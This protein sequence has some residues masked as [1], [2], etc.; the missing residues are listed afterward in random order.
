MGE[1]ICKQSNG[2]RINL[3][4]IQAAH[5]TQYK[6]EKSPIKKWVEDLNRHFFKADKQMVNKHMKQCSTQ[7]IIREIKTKTTIRYHLSVCDVHL[8]CSTYYYFTPHLY[9]HAIAGGLF[10]HFW[11]IVSNATMYICG[12]IFSFLLGRYTQ[13]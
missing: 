1:N 6:K 7:F 10:S 12:H 4:S 3:Q 9:I 2:Q 8:C 13:K 5:A 11:L